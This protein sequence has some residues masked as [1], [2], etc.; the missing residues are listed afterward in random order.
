MHLRT[1]CRYRHGWRWAA[2]AEKV[3]GR[4]RAHFS[5]ESERVPTYYLWSLLPIHLVVFLSMNGYYFLRGASSSSSS[6]SPKGWILRR[7]CP[8]RRSIHLCR[9]NEGCGRWKDFWEDRVMIDAEHISGEDLKKLKV[10][11]PFLYYSIPAAVRNAAVR[12]TEVRVSL[13][14]ILRPIRID[15][16]YP[17]LLNKHES[18]LRLAMEL[19]QASTIRFALNICWN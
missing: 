17:Y 4:Q 16:P 3:E 12:H 8:S 15:K 11:D 9:P 5:R 18:K 10:Q 19:K 2:W 7:W 6:S 14:N 13:P 1:I